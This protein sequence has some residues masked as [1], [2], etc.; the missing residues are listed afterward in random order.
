MDVPIDHQD[1]IEAEFVDRPQRGHGHVVEQAE[2]HGAVEQGVMAGRA[3]QAEGLG[4]LAGDHSAHGV[5]DAG[6][7]LLGDVKGGGADDRVAFDV[8]AAGLGQ[9]PDFV[10]IG[11]CVEAGQLPPIARLEFWPPTPRRQARLVQP[12]GDAAE[13]LGPFRVIAR[14]VLEETGMIVEQS[15][16]CPPKGHGVDPA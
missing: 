6:D 9:G 4:V 1:A 16:G 13:P 7:G 10:D 8:S 14:L 15:H 2:T 11:L 3:N 5:A 12:P